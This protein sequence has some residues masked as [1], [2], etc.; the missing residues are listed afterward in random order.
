MK[1]TMIVSVSMLAI[2]LTIPPLAQSA[3]GIETDRAYPGVQTTKPVPTKMT[4]HSHVEDKLGIRLPQAE[5]SDQPN[6][7]APAAEKGSLA[8]TKHYHPRDAK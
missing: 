8:K 6:G 3:D 2:M 4:P 7:T 5:A 1:R